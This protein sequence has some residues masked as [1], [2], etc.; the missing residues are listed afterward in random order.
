MIDLKN[1]RRDLDIRSEMKR[2]TPS[3]VSGDVESIPSHRENSTGASSRNLS[4]VATRVADPGAT[5]SNHPAG[6]G[7]MGYRIA[8]MIAMLLLAL[9]ALGI[10]FYFRG[11]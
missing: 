2:S 3:E 6:E 11:N 4:E 5:S 7:S 9:A 10:W 1:P 8:A